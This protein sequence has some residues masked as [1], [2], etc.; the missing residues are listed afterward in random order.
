M[1]TTS[2]VL[3]LSHP[4]CLQ[5]QTH[6]SISTSEVTL[7]DMVKTNHY[8]TTTKHNLAPTSSIIYG[9]YFTCAGPLPPSLSAV[10]D[11]HIIST[12]EVTL[13]D[14]VK[15]NHYHTTTKHN[16]APTSSIIYGNYF[17]C[18]GPLPPSLSAV[19][20]PHIY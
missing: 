15:T 7:M 9:N 13:M 16:L 20:D 12:S 4:V 18:A 6:T 10:P 5:Y 1:G 8:H 2:L 19:P 3:G 14:M 17:T 11:P